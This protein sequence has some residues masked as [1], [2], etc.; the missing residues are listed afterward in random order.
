MKSP[1]KVPSPDQAIESSS[2]TPVAKVKILIV[3]DHPITRQGLKALITQHPEFEVCGEA[4]SAPQ[5]VDL[6]GKLKPDLV[7]VDITLKTTN[8][9]ELIKNLRAQ[10]PQLRI[11]VVSMHDENLYAERALRAGAQGY[12]MKQEASDQIIPAIE[13]ILKGDLHLSAAVKDKIL[14]RFVNNGGEKAVSAIET[15]SDREMEVFQ[16]IGNGHSTRQIATRLNLSTK[17]IDS[18]REHLKIKLSLTT[19]SDL[20]QH[21]IQWVK[22]EGLV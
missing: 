8:G 6:L 21:A 4:D 22:S 16:L 3:D 18:Y 10:S 17:T 1:S 14:H 2:V 11:L 15:L 9:I 7:I 20:V 12:V 5:A 13:K 19:G